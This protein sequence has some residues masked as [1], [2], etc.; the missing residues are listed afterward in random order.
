LRAM[1]YTTNA[2]R[3]KEASQTTNRMKRYA[4]RYT[5]YAICQTSQ[6]D[7][8]GRQLDGL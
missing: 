2:R 3:R 8:H 4:I 1:W 5:R 7:K 6:E